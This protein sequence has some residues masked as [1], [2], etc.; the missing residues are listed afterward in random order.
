[1]LNDNC[2]SLS[3]T[4]VLPGQGVVQ[5]VTAS[6]II[7]V[8]SGFDIQSDPQDYW[9]SERDLSFTFRFCH[10]G[11]KSIEGFMLCD[12]AE[13]RPVLFLQLTFMQKEQ[14]LSNTFYPCWGRPVLF[15]NSWPVC[16]L[17][18]HSE[19]L[20]NQVEAGQS[21]SVLVQVI[22]TYIPQLKQSTDSTSPH[23]CL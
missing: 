21:L 13:G 18:S 15:L 22:H 23:P 10:K 8:E 16:K 12:L 4:A 5:T 2:R 9:K 6:G 11:L 14:S 19:I 7:Q 17:S 1:M 20:F 3:A